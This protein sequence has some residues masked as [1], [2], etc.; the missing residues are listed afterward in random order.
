MRKGGSTFPF[1][2]FSLVS[3][4][5]SSTSSKGIAID[6]DYVSKFPA[7]ERIS[8]YTV[9]CYPIRFAMQIIFERRKKKGYFRRC[10]IVDYMEM[11]FSSKMMDSIS[12]LMLSGN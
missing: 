1:S 12:Y 10:R 11:C 4:D 7:R 2:S 8:T 5:L 9:G 6:R 3:Y